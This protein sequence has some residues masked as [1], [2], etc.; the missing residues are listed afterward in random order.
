M[1]PLP[2][3]EYDEQLGTGFIRRDYLTNAYLQGFP[4]KESQ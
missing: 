3:R 2:S 1:L 4:T